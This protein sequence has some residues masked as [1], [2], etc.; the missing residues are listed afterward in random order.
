MNFSLQYLQKNYTFYTK[1]KFLWN[2]L[3]LSQKY[4]MNDTKIIILHQAAEIKQ[5]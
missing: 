3:I 2:V 5:L 4:V 1:I